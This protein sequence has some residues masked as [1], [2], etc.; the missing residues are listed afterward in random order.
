MYEH[1]NKTGSPLSQETLP[2]WMGMADVGNLSL[3]G[4]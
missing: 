3:R 4:N 2:H 1:V